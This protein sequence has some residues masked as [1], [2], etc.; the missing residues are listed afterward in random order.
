MTNLER[1][2]AEGGHVPFGLVAQTA[3]FVDRWGRGIEADRASG[4]TTDATETIGQLLRIACMM[5]EPI[6]ADPI[7]DDVLQAIIIAL[8]LI[9]P[10]GTE[11][12]V[13][14]LPGAH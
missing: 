7:P 5:L 13:N 3:S 11:R 12:I 4:E 9:D 10:E 6:I 1:D 2:Q 8:A 14:S